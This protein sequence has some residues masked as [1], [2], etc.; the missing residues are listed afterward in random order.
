M[1]SSTSTNDDATLATAA[2]TTTSTL[3]FNLREAKYDLLE[4]LMTIIIVATTSP[5]EGGGTSSSSL[6][7]M[8]CPQKIFK[9]LQSKISV[10]PHGRIPIE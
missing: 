4:S 6:S 5:T 10:G 9:Q 7:K 8:V 1:F 2:A 3:S